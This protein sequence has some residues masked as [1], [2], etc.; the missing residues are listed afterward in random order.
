MKKNKRKHTHKTTHTSKD[1]GEWKILIVVGEQIGA[2]TME[3]TLDIPKAI[4]PYKLILSMYPK[5]SISY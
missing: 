2:A 4:D 3:T 1:V 5:D